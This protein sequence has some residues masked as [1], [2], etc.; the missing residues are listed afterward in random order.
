M[1]TCRSLS[2]CP[3]LLKGFPHIL[4][5]H[6]IPVWCQNYMDSTRLWKTWPILSTSKY[7]IISELYM[8]LVNNLINNIYIVSDTFAAYRQTL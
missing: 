2:V 4:H 8:A 3:E 5:S 7:R 1:R 6:G